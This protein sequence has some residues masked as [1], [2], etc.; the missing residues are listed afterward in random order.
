MTP[1]TDLRLFHDRQ[2]SLWVSDGNKVESHK[3]TPMEVL[4]EY[5]PKSVRLYGVASQAE[6]IV[7][8]ATAGQSLGY[9]PQV[10]VGSPFPIGK[11]R[12][13]ATILQSM[14]NLAG[15]RPYFGGWRLVTEVDLRTYRFLD[16]M[17]RW[18]ASKAYDLVKEHPAYPALSFLEQRGTTADMANLVF[19]I[20][21]PRW[22]HRDVNHPDRESWLRMF[23]GITPRNVSCLVDGKKLSGYN[24][25][26]LSCL[27]HVMQGSEQVDVNKLTSHSPH[28][29]FQ[30]MYRKLVKES[31]PY[32][33][34]KKSL[35]LVVSFIR[36]VWLHEIA[37]AGREVFLPKY[38]F[39]SL[40]KVG[41]SV[42]GAYVRHRSNLPQKK[43]RLQAT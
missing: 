7:V 28:L 14:T 15:L 34:L 17:F 35:E 29:F 1:E 31:G 40:G 25:K 30:M 33:A 20:E 8:A 6:S 24:Y 38:F 27:L 43:A 16:A 32:E 2:G 41:A 18:E 13:S 5:R 12:D 23:L 21:D 11:L 37:P 3:A 22:F 9:D 19:A 36:Q 42:A 39:E 10:W 4:Q 26:R